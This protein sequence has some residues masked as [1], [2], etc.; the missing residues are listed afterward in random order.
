MATINLSEQIYTLLQDPL[1]GD[2]TLEIKILRLVEGALLYKL[3]QS[4]ALDQALAEK[5]TMSF[6]DFMER[7]T[8][9]QYNASWEVE[10]DATEWQ[11]AMADIAAIEDRL[12]EIR[13]LLPAEAA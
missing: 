7:R 8:S 5:Y 11:D 10:N 13:P 3:D 6:A 2:E 1:L 12:A 9:V 4:R